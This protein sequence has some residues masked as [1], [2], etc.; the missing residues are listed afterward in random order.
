[1]A[2]IVSIYHYQSLRSQ[3]LAQK[4]KKRSTKGQKYTY[5]TFSKKDN[6]KIIWNVKIH[7]GGTGENHESL[8]IMLIF[9]KSKIKFTISDK[10]CFIHLYFLY[11][12][13]SLGVWFL[14]HI[15]KVYILYL[16]NK[17]LSIM[18]KHV[19]CPSQHRIY[20]DY[21]NCKLDFWVFFPLL[22][23]CRYFLQNMFHINT[24]WY[25]SIKLCKIIFKKISYYHILRR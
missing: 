20:L 22:S 2:K 16:Y 18:S 10:M 7:F 23:I 13:G 14:K 17:C 3:N 24:F 8:W 4:G 19:E 11:F 25:F 21:E 12:L 5:H 9:R 1:M 6:K 15:F